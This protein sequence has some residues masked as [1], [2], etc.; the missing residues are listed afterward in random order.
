MIHLTQRAADAL[1][2]M[3]TANQ[4]PNDQGVKLFPDPSGGVAMMIAPASEGDEVVNEEGR[5]L[6]IVDAEIVG[7]VDGAVLDLTGSDDGKEPRFEFRRP[8]RPAP[9]S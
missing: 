8:P 2:E 6:L 3:L 7:R 4:T 5:L 9:A 1:K